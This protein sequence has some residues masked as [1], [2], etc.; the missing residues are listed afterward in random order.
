MTNLQLNQLRDLLE[1]KAY[2]LSEAATE[3]GVSY[4]CAKYHKDKHGIECKTPKNKRGYQY[5]NQYA[6]YDR[7]TDELLVIGTVHEVSAFLGI[8][9]ATFWCQK[10]NDIG[11]RVF[12]KIEDDDD[13]EEN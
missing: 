11:P 8:A 6:A 2:T 7:R 4:A 13:E 1:N 5:M 12:V 10:T 9:E 3:I